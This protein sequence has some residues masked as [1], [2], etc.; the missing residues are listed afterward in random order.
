MHPSH[1]SI[2]IEKEGTQEVLPVEAF[3][4]LVGVK[5]S[6][7]L[8]FASQSLKQKIQRKVE[9]RYRKGELSR[10]QMWFGSYYKE[11][12]SALRMPDVVLRYINPLFGW[13]VFANRDFKKM[14]FIAERRI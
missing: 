9:R 8:Q 6:T 2:C 10:Q 12:I 1:V 7:S 14:E 11:E 5:F 3:E 4:K 13:G